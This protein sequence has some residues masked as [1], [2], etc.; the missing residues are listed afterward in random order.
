[1]KKVLF[2]VPHLSTGGLPQYTF[3]LIDS[4]KNDY[5]VYCLEHKDI[6]GGIL[7]VQRNRISNL[8]GEKFYSLSNSS[9]DIH[10]II[11][12]I[13]PDVIHFQEIPETFITHEDL[14]KIYSDNR[15]YNIVV[16]THSS[17]T[18]PNDIIYTADK[19]I[20][21]SSWSKTKFV[22]VFGEEM[23]D[24]WEYPITSVSYNK[25]DAKKELN[26][27]S[28]YLHVL[29]VGLFTSGKNQKEL[30]D[31]ARKM[32]DEKIKFHF[33][34]NQ[35]QNFRDYWDPIMRN[36]PDNCIWHGEREDVDLFYKAAD[37]FYFPSNFELNP[38]VVKEALSYGLPVFMKKLESYGDEYDGIVNYI[39]GNIDDDIKKIKTSL[40]MENKSDVLT[41]ILAH[42]DTIYRKKLLMDCINS[43]D[44]EKLLSTNYMVDVDIQPMCDHVLYTKNNPL[45][46]NSD[47]EKYGLEYN[48]WWIDDNRKKHYKQ[49]DYEHGY[50]VYTL[51]QNALRYAKNLGK[52]N[53]HIVNYDY[54]I[55]D[56]TIKKHDNLIEE[57]DVVF[58]EQTDSAYSDVSY[59]T[60]FFSGNINTLQSFFEKYK[61]I[62]EYYSDGSGFNILERKIQKH[63][64]NSYCR[65]FTQSIN[66]LKKNNKLNR[67]GM[68]DLSKSEKYEKLSF[69]E[70]CKTFNCDKGIS[71]E[72]HKIY[73]TVLSKYKAKDVNLFEIGLDD[74]NSLSVWEN[75]LP[76]AKIHRMGVTK[77][78]KSK[79]GE[80]FIGDQNNIND[81][82]NIVKRIPKCQIIVDDGSHV[83]SHQLKSFY[84]LFQNLLDWGGVYVIE[85]IECSYWR[86]ETLIYGYETGHLNIVDYFNKLNHSV[87]SD[88]SNNKNDL[89]IRSISYYPN[90]IVIHKKSK[91]ELINKQYRFQNFL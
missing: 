37:I 28:S 79:R 83:A 52:H 21:V 55:D 48:Y 77:K 41:I 66:V 26:F 69:Q 8:L 85:D 81:L 82:T 39:S 71:H 23:C 67:E 53:V 62:D 75:F 30:I 40:S 38:L 47:F 91:D 70:L 15:R 72:Y 59:N 50:A 19:F 16:T 65:I 88:Y 6:T 24:I 45:L 43:I 84:Y 3:K 90:C 27:D 31:I 9:N 78:N 29:N 2:V 89:F 44:G 63:Y 46:F 17:T 74:E 73:E 25:D 13:D 14:E 18:N 22:D 57:Y 33:V 20:L 11:S 80:T 51:I 12:S 35:A 87:N 49:F 58:Y 76:L 4:L 54:V 42:A 86:P 56:I 5:D 32:K 7:T 34:G 10:A 61:N 60:G 36:F 1:V 64:E 68:L